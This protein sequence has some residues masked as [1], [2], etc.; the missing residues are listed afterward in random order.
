MKLKKLISFSLS[1]I[2]TLGC[3]PFA[4]CANAISQ[5]FPKGTADS[6]YFRI[7]SLTTINN[8]R[9][10]ASA[11]VRYGE[12]TDSPANIDTGVRFSDDNGES[13]SE[14]N[15]VNHFTDFEDV[16]ADEVKTSSASFID[17]T[18]VADGN[19][20]IYLLCDACPAFMGAP[21]AKPFDNGYI[22]GK[23]ALCDKTTEASLESEKL[24]ETHYPYYIADFE[25]GFA[26]VKK[27][28]D[29]TVYNG[30]YVDNEYNLYKMNNDSL[31]KVMIN[32][33]DKLGNKTEKLTQA[34]VFYACSPVK[35]YP[36]FYLWLR[37]S[38]DGGKSWSKP[39]I[40]NP[41]IASRGFTAACPGKGLVCQYNGSERVLFPIYDN[42]DG[43]ERTSVIFS[44]DGGATWQRSNKIKGGIFG[45]KSSEGQL[46]MMNNGTL[47]MYSRNGAGYI[48]YSDSL[49][50][51]AT[52]GKY[53]LDSE[54]KYCSNCMVSFI[55]YSG[56]ID[57]Q[58]AII[59]SYPSAK[60]RKKGVVRIGLYDENNKVNWKYHY[61][62]TSDETDFTFVYSCLAE[63]Q[64]GNIALFYENDKAA[65]TYT[66][67]SPE[68]L[69]VNDKKDTVFSKIAKFFVNLFAG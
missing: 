26:P 42:N 12:G 56:T 64:D 1:M 53:H 7:P 45:I 49:D 18:A 4:V 52:W 15:L 33:L 28:S 30:F 23:I 48:G 11:D 40:L 32:Q 55:N 10:F 21:Y 50:G 37:T 25:N 60:K 67:Y 35:I 38:D 2:F 8:G 22:N 19:G 16:S 9:V 39:Y 14:I 31:E 62:A 27:F 43:A 63:L 58:K 6:D 5:P 66:T 57:G 44:D 13:W 51:G 68:E 24:D 47:R 3:F 61:S 20:K 69:S 65:L 29:N 34:N 46:V 17:S 36:A 54:L 41:Q 59:A